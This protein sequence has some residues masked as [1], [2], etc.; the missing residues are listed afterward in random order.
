MKDKFTHV[1]LYIDSIHTIKT[2][3]QL[4]IHDE[5][6]QCISTPPLWFGNLIDSYTS[7]GWRAKHVCVGKQIIVISA[8]FAALKVR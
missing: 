1:N 2:I 5:N 6:N 4:K 7:R 8:S 3:K